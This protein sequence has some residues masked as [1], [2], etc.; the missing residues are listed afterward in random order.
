M[1]QVYLIVGGIV[2]IALCIFALMASQSSARNRRVR[3][4]RIQK[5]N[6]HNRQLRSLLRVM[7]SGSISQKL[8][9]YVIDSLKSNTAEI[10]ENRPDNV[11]LYQAELA[12]LESGTV[13]VG[14]D[15]AGEVRSIE[16][17]NV[18]RGALAAL[19]KEIQTQHKNGRVDKKQ[20][21]TLLDEVDIQLALV[22]G[23]FLERAGLASEKNKKYREA[24]SAWQKAMDT[25]ANSRMK[26][27]FTDEAIK[28]RGFIKRAQ[29]EWRDNKQQLIDDRDAAR[30]AAEEAKGQPAEDDTWQKPNLYD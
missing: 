20:A 13:N 21:Q 16:Q 7:P 17:V 5:L 19:A 30:A 26:S 8:L 3:A 4:E 29:Q 1:A 12:D 6:Q 24:I 15:S 11:V 23:N 28:L 14:G 2:F 27:H 10:I 18:I 9:D 25:Y 22:A